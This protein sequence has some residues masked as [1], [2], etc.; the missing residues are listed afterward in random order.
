M[1][2]C[3]SKLLFITTYMFMDNHLRGNLRDYFS[4]MVKNMM[5][6]RLSI[7][8]EIRVPLVVGTAF[9]T[10]PLIFDSA[11]F[12]KTSLF[13]IMKTIKTNIP[14]IQ[15]RSIINDAIMLGKSLATSFWFFLDFLSN[16]SKSISS[17][18]L[19]E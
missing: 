16:L 9:F 18:Y 10:A 14:D 17:I 13:S 12:I 11:L 15:G 1:F 19:L 3:S 8:P 4:M 5:N 2:F 7:N 6:V